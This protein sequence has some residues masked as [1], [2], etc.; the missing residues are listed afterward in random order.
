MR[1]ALLVVAALASYAEVRVL[2]PGNA[3]KPVGPYSP[4]LVAGDYLYVSGQGAAGAQGI[5]AQTRLCLNNIKAILEAGGLG[6]D[7]VVYAQVYLADIGNYEGLNR[8]WRE[9]FAQPP[10]RSAAGVARMPT[11]TPIEITVV[12]HR[13]KKQPVTLTGVNTPVPISPGVFTSDRFYF[14]GILGRDSNTGQI[15]DALEAQTAM[16][17]SRLDRVLKTAKVDKYSTAFVT[18]YHTPRMTLELA[19]RALTNYFGD[20]IPP[21]AIVEVPS[22]PFGANISMTGIAARNRKDRTSK[23]D[24]SWIGNTGFCSLSENLENA[25]LTNVVATN[26]YIDSIDEFSTMNARYAAA[27]AGKTLPTRTTLQPMPVGGQ[28]KFRFSYVTVRP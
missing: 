2:T 17:T 24:C 25:D 11:D 28:T 10:A 22:L 9:M 6:L 20:R 26:V 4:G 18:V 21:H 23:G 27:F 8:V 19:S 15:P 12:A 16:V 3:P 1:L 7:H 13:K 14:S 5:E